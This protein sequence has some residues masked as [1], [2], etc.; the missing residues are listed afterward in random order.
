MKRTLIVSFIIGAAISA[1]AAEPTLPE[2][3]QELARTK[4][5]LELAE[6]KLALAGKEAELT[7]VTMQAPG[8]VHLASLQNEDLT[9]VLKQADEAKAVKTIV[10]KS[11]VNLKT[12]GRAVWAAR[13]L[14]QR[15]FLADRSHVLLDAA[16]K[17]QAV[18][19][20]AGLNGAL[21]PFYVE[22]GLAQKKAENTATP[23]DEA[24]AAGKG[25]DP[26]VGE[27]GDSPEKVFRGIDEDIFFRNAGISF[28]GGY[29]LIKDQSVGAIIAR[30]NVRQAEA[31]LWYNNQVA[32][33]SKDGY[34]QV[35]YFG[36]N[37]DEFM[38]WYEK[39]RGHAASERQSWLTA[40]GPFIGGTVNGDKIDSGAGEERPYL[41]GLSFGFGFSTEAASLFYV[42]VGTTISPKQGLK[43]N[44]LYVGFSADAELLGK[45]FDRIRGKK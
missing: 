20:P 26:K 15:Q 25:V 17:Q 6:T 9:A 3:N 12:R 16:A 4:A 24:A 1:L 31:T 45:L 13:G 14:A 5:Q 44:K 40:W 34:E 33:A 41:L 23:E 28:S 37:R 2:I 36:M 27:Q 32:K 22:L 29:G 7:R 8:L 38:G 21:D 39:A 42:D 11:E 35:P 43:S 18:N 10:E 30:W 19:N